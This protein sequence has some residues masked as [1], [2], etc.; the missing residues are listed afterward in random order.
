MTIRKILVPLSGQYD[1]EDPAALD[2]PALDTGFTLGA[3]FKAHVEVFCVESDVSF[4]RAPLAPWVP[5]HAMEDLIDWIEKLSEQR[6]TRARAAFDAAVKRWQPLRSKRPSASAGPSVEF[7]E[8][9]GDVRDSIAYR[10]RL[11]DLI[12]TA[13]SSNEFGARV[14]PI[15][16]AAL[17]ETGRPVLISPPDVGQGI[18]D[19]VLIAWNGSSEASRAVALSKE[20]LVG[21]N[22]VSIIFVREDDS[23]DPGPDD[24]A[25]YLKWLGIE[26]RTITLQGTADTAGALILEQ[27][28]EMAADLLVMGAYTRSR[29]RRLIFGGVTNQVLAH[30]SIPVLM[31]D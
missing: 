21:A 7:L 14:P 9:V 26:A 5:G 8:Q 18:G 31:V 24:L 11:A 1:P 13:N 17:R 23:R 6:R 3:R 16:D 15:L 27:A 25:D 29:A 4:D 2:R 20:F 10:G 28:D 12:V 30:M 19:R 22:E